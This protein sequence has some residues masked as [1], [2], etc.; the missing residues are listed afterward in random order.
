MVG[1][2]QLCPF[3]RAPAPTLEEDALKRVKKRM[4]VMLVMLK[5]YDYAKG[6]SGLP[7]VVTR[8]L[9]NYGIGLES[10]AMP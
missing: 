6:T 1:D 5:H 3:C 9:E 8:Y 10:L 2:D 7:Q 4:D